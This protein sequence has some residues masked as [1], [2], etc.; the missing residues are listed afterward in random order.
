MFFCL[1]SKQ[2][3]LLL[4]CVVCFILV[5]Y[6]LCF[7][8]T[9]CGGCVVP[10]RKTQQW[11]IKTVLAVDPGWTTFTG[12]IS[13]S[14]TLLNSSVLI[15]NRTLLVL[16]S[17]PL[18]VNQCIKSKNLVKF[19][20][21]GWVLILCLPFHTLLYACLTVSC[22]KVFIFLLGFECMHFITC[23]HSLVMFLLF[24]SFCFFILF[25]LVLL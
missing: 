19:W 1:H 2:E 21:L 24:F 10:L 17:L 6:V 7:H 14:F 5:V 3:L 25:L 4:F 23:P 9:F 16:L 22:V 20:F 18:V 13:N 12:P 15:M 8:F 11:Q